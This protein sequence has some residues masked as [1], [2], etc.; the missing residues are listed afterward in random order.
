MGKSVISS[1]LFLKKCGDISGNE[2]IQKCSSSFAG[3]EQRF[4][5]NRTKEEKVVIGGAHF[6]YFERE[7][8]GDLKAVFIS[9]ANQLV[10]FV[11]GLLETLEFEVKP[12]LESLEK[13]S[14]YFEEIIAKPCRDLNLDGNKMDRVVLIFDALDECSE[15]SRKHL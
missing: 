14:D 5:L 9:L 1:Q 11:P 4:S 13:L 10:E 15:G 7:K 8:S 2:E 3:L 12:K 6:F